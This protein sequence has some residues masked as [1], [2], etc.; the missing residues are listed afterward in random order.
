[1]RSCYPAK[2]TGYF[3]QQRFVLSA[4]S[5]WSGP[6]PR[7]AWFRPGRPSQESLG[8]ACRLRRHS[9]EHLPRK[10]DRRAPCSTLVPVAGPAECV[11]N[12]S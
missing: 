8:S 3:G 2:R 1:T 12:K 7:S 9:R 5:F 11:A 6:L 10:R 4:K